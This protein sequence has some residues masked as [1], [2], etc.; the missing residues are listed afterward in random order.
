MDDNKGFFET[1]L[2]SLDELIC[3]IGI[4]D[5]FK[6][7]YINSK[8]LNRI[9]RFSSKKLLNKSLLDLVHPEE[10]KA[11]EYV[12]SSIKSDEIKTIN[13]RIKTEKG[14]YIWFELII[15]QLDQKN[16]T[17]L[18]TLREIGS[19]ITLKKRIE[20]YEG[21]LQQLAELIPEIRFWRLFTPKK[22]EEALKTSHEML[23]TIIESIPQYI[24]WKDLNLEYMG[25]NEKFAKLIGIGQSLNILGKKNGELEWFK[26]RRLHHLEVR[27]KEVLKNNMP[28]LNV[29]ESWILDDGSEI[30]VN[31]NRIPL[32]DSRG[33][34]MGIL[35]TCEDITARKLADKKLKDSEKKYRHLFEN[36]PNMVI[37]IDIEGTFLDVNEAF[38][39][40]SGF[41]KD[42]LIGKNFTEIN[43]TPENFVIFKEYLEKINE[44]G[45]IGPVEILLRDFKKDYRWFTLRGYFTEIEDTKV[46]HVILEDIHERKLIQ[47][48]IKESEE[49]YRD[50]L[51]TSSVGIIEL[52]LRKQEILYINP[53][54]LQI[55]GYE[56]EII[57]S[58]TLISKIFQPK[59][60]ERILEASDEEELEF[61]IQ[62]KYGK[63]KWLSGKK[64]MHYDKEGNMISFR[65]WLEDVTDKKIYEKLLYELNINFLNFSLDIKNNIFLLLDNCKSLLNS[66][67]AIYVFIEE[68]KGEEIFNILTSEKEYLKV[69]SEEFYDKFFASKL[70]LEYHDF[71]QLYFNIHE[72]EYKDF[73]PLIKNHHLVGCYG[74]LLKIKEEI[75]GCTCA[76]FRKNPVISYHDQYSLFLISVAL[77]IERR[78]W[79]AQ[80]EL[81]KQNIALS[82]INKLKTELLSRTSHELK[83]PLIS[84]KGF[85]ELLLTLYR[86]KFDD[87][88]L[89]I[90][91]EIR[92][93]SEK[94]EKIINSLLESSRLEQGRLILKPEP[95]D[96][97]FL[98]H[99][100]VKELIGVTSL[101]NQEL[102]VKVQDNLI[103]RFDK[104][105]IYEVLSNLLINAIKYTPP[106]G[107]IIVSSEEKDGFYI[108]SIQDNGIGFTEEEKRRVF[109]QF[110]K[111]ERYGKGWNL[112][113]EGTGLGLY[114]SK[115]IIELHGGKIWLE[116]EGRNKG[117]TFYFSLP[118]KK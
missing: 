44:Q 24:A 26:K 82:E 67:L 63:L 6:I 72:S 56:K 117:S 73:D 106:N 115:K 89:S 2:N 35:I 32:H 19:E 97:S 108:I 58:E 84:I 45:K 90:L 7:R 54:L 101:R 95:E 66:D 9:L 109:K 116:S 42:D 85:T 11:L 62:D 64:V 69:A 86:N 78:R 15:K 94:L 114:I 105:R 68:E 55:L 22:F 27:E 1:I 16:S 75:N 80:K 31:I 88:I 20:D 25:C 113:I 46:I 79:N 70:F 74:R 71:P 118:I 23:K 92:N 41:K 37:L 18:I 91:K 102:I 53:K 81:E 39:K 43:L 48:K 38:L 17:L 104:E 47:N 112:N 110:G 51:E 100:C 40:F 28:E 34:V 21:N 65:L 12:V 29:S 87:E 77:D 93:G 98:I 5:N 13:C 96:L 10:K 83:T 99:Y 4:H 8:F 61:Q 49:R 30:W 76:F 14:K 59:D 107:K 103:T 52:D 3:V 36:S 60:Y 111:I 50:L 33:K 57:T